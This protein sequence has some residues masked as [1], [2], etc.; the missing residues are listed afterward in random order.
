MLVDV[1]CWHFEYLHDTPRDRALRAHNPSLVGDPESYDFPT[2]D[3]LLQHLDEPG[4]DDRSRFQQS[5][6]ERLGRDPNVAAIKAA[7]TQLKDLKHFRAYRGSQYDRYHAAARR[8][9]DEVASKADQKLID[10]FDVEIASSRIS[11]SSGQILFHGRC[12]DLLVTE[13]PYPSYVSA[14]LDPIVALNSAFRRAGINCVNGRPIVLVLKLCVPLRA[15]WGHV[16]KSHEWEL[17]LPRGVDWKETERRS[18][19]AFDIIHATAVAE[20]KYPNA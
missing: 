1:C 9:A 17:L 7:R 5:I 14:T 19:N 3:A 13:H 16:G 18:G 11:L 6:G 2:I 15:L 20:S 8:I 10:G 12:N 4:N